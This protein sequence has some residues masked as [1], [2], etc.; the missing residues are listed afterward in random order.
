MS[1]SITGLV[2]ML[3]ANPMISG[4]PASWIIESPDAK[5]VSEPVFA[6]VKAAGFDTKIICLVSEKG[7]QAA[8]V[9]HIDEQK[10]RI[11]WLATQ[12]QGESVVY[13]HDPGAG[14][15]GDTFS[16]EN[17]GPQS[18]RLGFSGRPVIQYEFP[19]FDTDDIEHTKKPFHHVFSPSGDRLITKG[20][21]GRFSHHRG[22][23]LGFYAF[24]DGSDKRVDIWH[25]RNGERSEH[26]KV[27][28]T[29]GGP[30]LGG[31]V[32]AI[33]WKDHDGEI[34]VTEEREVRT[35]RQPAGQVLIDVRSRLT[36][37]RDRV[38]LAGDRHHAGLQFRASQDVA[39]NP[40]TTRFIRPQAWDHIP[41]DTELGDEDIH[42]FPWNSMYFEINGKAY[43]VAY[44]SHP[45]NP[46]DAEMSERLYGRFGEFFVKELERGQSFDMNYRFWIK[47]GDAPDQTDIQRRFEIYAH[48]PKIKQ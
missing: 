21:G 28:R 32:L 23:F 15:E 27:V 43:T 1:I 38:L 31:H 3:L 22:I 9:E 39:D 2:L 10:A 5:M 17:A 29:M 6:E 41:A 16:W 36:A 19:V 44:M 35:Y 4:N 42:D 12:N 34:F 25:A 14:C 26:N 20:P 33:D 48:P 37:H 47:E 7:V 45:S 13:R 18:T 30:V 8:Q 11:W 46:A 24:I 40:E